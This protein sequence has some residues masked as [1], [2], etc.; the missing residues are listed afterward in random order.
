[1]STRAL[2]I[3][4]ILLGVVLALVVA[5]ALQRYGRSGGAPVVQSWEFRNSLL[6]CKPGTLAILRPGR[7]DLPRQRYWFLRVFREPQP[8]DPDA[9]ESEVGGYAHVRAGVWSYNKAEA[10]WFYRPV[11]YFAYRQMGALGSKQWLNGIRMVREVDAS[12]EERE[13][14]RATFQNTWSAAVMS[15]TVMLKLTAS[16]PCPTPFTP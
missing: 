1:M 14:L 12:G 8:D 11:A 2:A 3:T 15:G 16:G 13:L 4:A 9:A 10:G 5:A 6:E 7:V